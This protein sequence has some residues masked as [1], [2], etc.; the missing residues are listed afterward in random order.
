M[1]SW[2][3]L[4]AQISYRGNLRD[5]VSGRLSVNSRSVSDLLSL[6]RDLKNVIPFPEPRKFILFG[7]LGKLLYN[8]SMAQ[9]LFFFKFPQD[10][11]TQ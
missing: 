11:Q 6:K 8:L 4:L 10:L 5:N 2:A 3:T 9:T 1:T 7:K